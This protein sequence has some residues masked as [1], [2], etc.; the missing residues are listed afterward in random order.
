[1]IKVTISVIA[2]ALSATVAAAQT[3]PA[4]PTKVA[5]PLAN[6]A[7]AHAVV[8]PNG[9]DAMAST[10]GK[11]NAMKFVSTQGHGVVQRMAMAPVAGTKPDK[12]SK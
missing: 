7:S 12:Q 1:M 10:A 8:A 3:S 6:K 9:R 11:S 5:I 2:L 4:P